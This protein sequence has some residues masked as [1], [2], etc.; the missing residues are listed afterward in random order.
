MVGFIGEYT[1]KLDEKGRV[2]LPATFRSGA[3]CADGQTRLVLQ[4]DVFDDCLVLKTEKEWEL[5][6]RFMTEMLNPY[7]KEHQQ[8]RRNLYRNMAALELDAAG[9]VLLPK[10]LIEMVGVVKEVVFAG[11]GDKIEVWAKDRY[12][13]GGLGEDAVAVLAEKILG[14]NEIDSQIRG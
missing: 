14:K 8:L 5:Q 12:E 9:R 3:L 11:Q 4:K 7:N 2:L 10:R 1:C 6:M 13:D